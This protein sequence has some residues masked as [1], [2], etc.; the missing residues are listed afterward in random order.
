MPISLYNDTPSTEQ[1]PA[2][3][4][5][6]IRLY[7]ETTNTA[8]TVSTPSP[9]INTTP[10]KST[11]PSAKLIPYS[12]I[13]KMTPEQKTAYKATL[14]T[15]INKVNLPKTLLK[16]GVKVVT[17]AYGI[18]KPEKK[19][20]AFGQTAQKIADLLINKSPLP[21]KAKEV[22]KK[23]TPALKA[24]SPTGSISSEGTGS[25]LRTGAENLLNTKIGRKVSSTVT[26]TT[27]NL[28]IKA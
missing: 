10:V 21:E 27:S 13:Q 12:E 15:D 20:N 4:G 16:K 17:D 23:I 9:I 28:P 6:A 3:K 14:K 19:E 11:N 24:V 18:T 22:A 26:E 7:P 8:P 2:S 25:L 5:S 1:K